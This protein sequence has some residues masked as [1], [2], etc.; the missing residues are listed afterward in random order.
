MMRVM[1][2]WFKE[3]NKLPALGSDETIGYNLDIRE[4]FPTYI[5][6]GNQNEDSSRPPERLRKAD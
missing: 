3:G 4:W 5:N 6:G 2:Y 1:L